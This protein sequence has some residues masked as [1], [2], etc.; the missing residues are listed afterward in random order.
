MCHHLPEPSDQTAQSEPAQP[1]ELLLRY[2]DFYRSEVAR[3][4]AGL[5]DAELRA[6]ALPTGW[7]PLE[8][9]NHLVHM[10][11]R[12]LVWGFAG[13]DVEQPWGDNG[14][15]GRWAVD[16]ATSRA[17]L[18]GALHEG[19]RRTRA[20]VE[21]A[22]LTDQG[23]TGGRFEVG[24][25]PPTLASILFHVLHEYARHVGHLDI[26]RELVDGLV[27]DEPGS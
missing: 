18:V 22:E 19:G 21:D 5:E 24:R 4:V 8:L 11:R 7:S 12:W 25:P 20:I 13:E 3:K 26:A 6:S 27:G 17:D 1:R 10:E 15:D 9:V 2:L 23:A 14:A 16:S